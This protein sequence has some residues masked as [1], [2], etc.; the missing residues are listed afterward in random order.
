M[1]T[2]TRQK[3]WALLSDLFV[4]TENSEQELRAIGQVLKTTGFSVAE[5]E[6]ILRKEVAPVCGRWMVNPGPMGSRTKCNAEL[7]RS[8]HT[9]FLMRRRFATLLSATMVSA[10]AVQTR[11]KTVTGTYAVTSEHD[12]G[13][14]LEVE[15]L[16]DC[17]RIHFA[18]DCTLGAP[19]YNLGFAED[20]VS[21]ARRLAVWRTTEY[22]GE[23]CELR[24]KFSD[25]V[26]AVK[27][28]GSDVDCGFGAHVYASGTYMRT[29]L[30][31]PRFDHPH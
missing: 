17:T 11:P 4:D 22:S 18:V 29:S 9:H 24:M 23:S 21:I 10:S 6:L 27:Q 14:V 1:S 8:H 31:T 19:S 30:T 2:A 3:V 5:V 20:T 12:A 26:V 25:G 15:Q 13:C 28:N 16:A 7:T